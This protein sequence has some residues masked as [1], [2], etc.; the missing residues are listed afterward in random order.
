MA[1]GVVALEYRP[2]RPWLDGVLLGGMYKGVRLFGSTIE[3][4]R[5]VGRVE[6]GEVGEEAPEE[7]DEDEDEEARNCLAWLS[8]WARIEARMISD[9]CWQGEAGATES[10][11][12]RDDED[13]EG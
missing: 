10:G 12:S 11:M 4:A 8:F 6:V 13:K 2:G 9:S 1:A 5:E 7:E 3:M